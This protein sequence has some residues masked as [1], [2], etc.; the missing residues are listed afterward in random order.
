MKFL[1][2]PGTHQKPCPPATPSSSQNPKPPSFY[3]R[4]G[5]FIERYVVRVLNRFEK[6]WG[7]TEMAEAAVAPGVTQA[8]SI[9]SVAI[10]VVGAVA[11]F[12]TVLPEEAFWATF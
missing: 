6:L 4:C 5:T 1:G 12:V 7:L 9:E 10:A 2:L 11:W 8:G 3:M